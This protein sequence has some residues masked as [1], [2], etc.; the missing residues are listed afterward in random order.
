MSKDEE[1]DL[2]IRVICHPAGFD[3]G[4]FGGLISIRSHCDGYEVAWDEGKE[5]KDFVTLQAAA[6]FFVDKRYELQLGLDI[7]AELMKEQ[8]V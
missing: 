5:Y 8:H 6:E 3:I 4:L 1:V 7:E 2:I